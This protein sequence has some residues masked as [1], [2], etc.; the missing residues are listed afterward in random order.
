MSEIYWLTRLDHLV[1]L[2]NVCAFLSI[3]LL[4]ILFAFIIDG[5][6]REEIR[7]KAKTIQTVSIIVFTISF[8]GRVFIPTEKEMMMILGLGQTIDYI[9]EN[10]T[11]KELPDKCVEALDAWVESLTKEE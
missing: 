9:Q 8:F 10:K 11:I 7:Q 2:F 1:R 6:L 5:D 3:V 4:L